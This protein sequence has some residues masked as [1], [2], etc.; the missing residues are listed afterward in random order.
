MPTT[1]PALFFLRVVV[2]V[3]VVRNYISVTGGRSPVIR[4]DVSS[5][6]LVFFFGLFF[7]ITLSD[8]CCFVI[9]IVDAFTIIF[10]VRSY[11]DKFN[12]PQ[13]SLRD[14]DFCSSWG[15]FLLGFS[16]F[17]FVFLL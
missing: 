6:N 5:G 3:V 9:G 16:P 11:R 8:S 17:C 4:A 2:V 12:G 10:R 14:V 13:C 7:F 1:L 15:C